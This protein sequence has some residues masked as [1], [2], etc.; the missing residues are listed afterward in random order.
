LLETAV[1]REWI[2]RARRRCLL[3]DASKW[4]S[5]AEIRFA[6]WNEFTDFY[7]DKNP[8]ATFNHKKLKTIIS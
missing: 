2:L 1:K 7:T 3:A 5:N 6:K 8:P 4:R